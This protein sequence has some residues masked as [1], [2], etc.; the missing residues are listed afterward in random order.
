MIHLTVSPTERLWSKRVPGNDP[1]E[2]TVLLKYL[3]PPNMQIL[4]TYLHSTEG[5]R[6]IE[7]EIIHK[8]GAT[9][10]N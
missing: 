8:F 5:E 1:E 9:N 7:K 2:G 4:M 3:S 10:T 6:Y